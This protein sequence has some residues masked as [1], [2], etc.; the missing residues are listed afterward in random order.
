MSKDR[1]GRQIQVRFSL[2][3]FLGLLL[4]WVL[5]AAFAFYFG[6]IAGRMAEVRDSLQRAARVERIAP[7]EEGIPLSF[8]ESLSAGAPGPGGHTE[9]PSREQTSGGSAEG[10]SSAV[11]SV[12]ETGGAGPL[13][14]GAGDRGVAGRP[15]GK[16]EE[17]VLQIGAFR[18]LQRAERL[19]HSLR[20]KGYPAYLVSSDSTSDQGPSHRVQVGPFS[21]SAEAMRTKELLE[22]QE[23][24][25][26]VMVLNKPAAGESPP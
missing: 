14:G 11:Q 10:S 9:K 12:A 6:T 2:F 21:D 18:D 15:A 24:L 8:P 20:S 3:S 26:R 22:N 16:S 17:K 1:R 5:I 4:C 25:E 19:V 13:N 23:A 7:P